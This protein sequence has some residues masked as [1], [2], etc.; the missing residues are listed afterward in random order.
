MKNKQLIVAVAV[1]MEAV[2]P[3]KAKEIVSHFTIKELTRSET[4]ARLGLDNTPPR[5]AVE[6]MQRLIREVLDPAREILGMPIIVN[7][8]YRCKELN[9]AVGGVARSYHLFGRAADLTTG[10]QQ[11]NRMLIKILQ[12]L[13]H[14]ELIWE[15]GGAW[16][17]VAY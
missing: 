14:V 4:A 15:R 1:A 6:N 2:T 17:H 8:G 16:I 3:V 7:S 11:G 10:T 12:S 9:S 13:P 5:E